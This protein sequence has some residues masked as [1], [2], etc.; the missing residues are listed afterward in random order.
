MGTEWEDN[1][2][3]VTN[4]LSGRTVIQAISI[5]LLRPCIQVLCYTGIIHTIFKS[6][7]WIS[8]FNFQ[9]IIIRGYFLR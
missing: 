3:K 7:T 4:L 9:F 8:F 1:L 6:Y 5:L 2:P